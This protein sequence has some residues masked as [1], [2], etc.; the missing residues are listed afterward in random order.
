[1]AT[2]SSECGA[3]TAS[4]TQ[5]NIYD[6]TASN[7]ADP[8]S[9]W[10]SVARSTGNVVT[11]D[12]QPPTLTAVSSGSMTIVGGGAQQTITPNTDAG[13]STYLSFCRQLATS[14]EQSKSQ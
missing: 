14:R 4:P 1:M 9:L 3:R 7:L 13:Q 5:L 6:S 10:V 11:S 12:N 2:I 8:L